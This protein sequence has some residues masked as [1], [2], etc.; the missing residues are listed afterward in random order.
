[1]KAALVLLIIFISSS[2]FAQ[3]DLEEQAKG[4]L[5]QQDFNTTRSNKER[6]GNRNPK[7][8]AKSQA[9][10]MPPPPPAPMPEPTKDSNDVHLDWYQ[11]EFH[12]AFEYHLINTA[13]SPRDKI[14]L[15]MIYG[16]S[17][18]WVEEKGNSIIIIQDFLKGKLFLVDTSAKTVKV[19]P[20]ESSNSTLETH[21]FET[22]NEKKQI[23]AITCLEYTDKSINKNDHT[24]IWVADTLELDVIYQQY[25]PHIKELQGYHLFVN[26]KKPVLEQINHSVGKPLNAM[27]V[28]NVD[29]IT[30]LLDLTDYTL[31]P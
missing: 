23:D 31:I 26:G 8:K 2:L 13:P 5:E 15:K 7:K 10:A 24:V 20:L 21:I 11:F 17:A 29:E 12:H 27:K 22:T 30:L 18:C 4:K 6:G 14:E 28:I 16:K 3:V 25:K 1:M 19:E 9:E